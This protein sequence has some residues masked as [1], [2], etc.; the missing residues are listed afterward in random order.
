MAY[1]AL[2]LITRSY[3]LSQVVARELQTVSGTQITDGLY[4]LNAMLNFKG[5]D[6]RN[7]PYFRRDT[8][9]AVQGQEE[10]FIEHLVYLD[11]LT[12]NIGDVRY[13]LIDATRKNYFGSPRVD[14]I[15]SLPYMYRIERELGGSRIFL[16]FLPQEAYVMKL[17][18]KFEFDE[19]TLQT[20]LSLTYDPFYIE[21]LRYSL[22]KKICEEWGSTFPDE[23]KKALESMEKKIME[24]SPPDLSLSK[25]SYFNGGPVLDWQAVNLWKGW[26]P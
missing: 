26:W 11:S 17:S 19:V 13:S 16:Y 24:V 25:R 2:Q 6:I 4:L 14:N 15:Q 7:I 22:A 1:T 23:S 21:F 12:F 18:G 3:Y 8:F 20:D 10:Y 5:T 9:N